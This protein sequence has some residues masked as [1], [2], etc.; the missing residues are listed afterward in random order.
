[1]LKK[2]NVKAKYEQ[3]AIL[4]NIFETVSTKNKKLEEEYYKKHPKE[5]IRFK[6]LEILHKLEKE[7]I[8]SEQKLIIRSIN[9]IDIKLIVINLFKEMEKYKFDIDSSVQTNRTSKLKENPSRYDILN[10]TMLYEHTINCVICTF[11]VCKKQ[12]VPQAITDIIVIL[13]LLHDSG[14]S[15]KIVSQFTTDKN[16]A[17]KHNFLSASYAKKY[18]K[19]YINIAISEETYNAISYVLIHHHRDNKITKEEAEELQYKGWIDLLC[20]ADALAREKE[21]AFYEM[22]H[23]DDKKQIDNDKKQTDKEESKK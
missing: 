17:T 18:L 11:D 1:M 2:K 4:H 22:Q 12:K 3:I 7:I 10:K 15:N 20:E 14:K 13:A 5:L 9:N 19:K 23:K 6:K 21:M 8:R 16:I